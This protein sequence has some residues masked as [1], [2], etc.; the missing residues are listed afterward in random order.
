M[1]ILSIIIIEWNLWRKWDKSTSNVFVKEE[2]SLQ[3]I[4]TT[5]RLYIQIIIRSWTDLYVRKQLLTLR[6]HSEK[7]VLKQSSH[8]CYLLK[9]L[10]YNSQVLFHHRDKWRLVVSL[11]SNWKLSVQFSSVSID[12][13]TNRVDV[14]WFS[15]SKCSKN[16][17]RKFARESFYFSRGNNFY[18]KKKKRKFQPKLNDWFLEWKQETAAPSVLIWPNSNY[19]FHE[20]PLLSMLQFANDNIMPN[21]L[22]HFAVKIWIMKMNKIIQTKKK[23]NKLEFYLKKKIKRNYEKEVEFQ[24]KNILKRNYDESKWYEEREKKMSKNQYITVFVMENGI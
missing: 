17:P 21:A 22:H 4:R 24:E 11:A 14:E 2:V 5:F 20:V 6:T 8:A 13:K 7:R 12:F 16:F 18:Q 15:V 19:H 1:S 9:L 10:I 3:K 23:T